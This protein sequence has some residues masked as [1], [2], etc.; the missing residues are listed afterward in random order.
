[1]AASSPAAICYDFTDVSRF[2]RSVA[3]TVAIQQ[4]TRTEWVAYKD[5]AVLNAVY[6]AMFWKGP[7]GSVEVRTA[8]AK[9]L[10]EA[11]NQH[12]QRYLLA[13]LR[14]LGELGPKGADD[15]IAHMTK[16]RAEVRQDVHDVFR[17]AAEINAQVSGETANAIRNLARIKLGATVGVALIGATGALVLSGG[18]ALVATGVSAG[19]SMT[20]SFIKEYENGR[21]AVAAGVSIEAGKATASETL[22]WVA[23]KQAANA[24]ARE[25]RAE[26]ILRG[27]EGVIR[28][29]SER[30]A[31]LAS[32][33]GTK[34]VARQTAKSQQILGIHQR[35]AA[36]QQSTIRS[37]QTVGKAARVAKVG[38]PLVF[39]AWDILEGINDYEQTVGAL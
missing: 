22:G 8:D 1:M 9:V 29:Q 11:A 4:Y 10:E 30:L 13:W 6:G 5:S 20:C 39:A 12:Q 36:A 2:C 31:R 3:M 17:E 34:R 7:P 23:G 33:R 32:Q 27:A 14:K 38:V 35:Q 28:Q 37:A 25:A 26:Q 15:Y 24:L 18:T 16:L 19:Y 21:H